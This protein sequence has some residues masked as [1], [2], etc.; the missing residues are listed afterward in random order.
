[1][2][3]LIGRKFTSVLYTCAHTQWSCEQRHTGG[4]CIVYT[5]LG[6]H[7]HSNGMECGVVHSEITMKLTND[8]D[9]LCQWIKNYMMVIQIIMCVRALERKRQHVLPKSDRFFWFIVYYSGIRLDCAVQCT[10]MWFHNTV[11]LIHSFC[12]TWYWFCLLS[13]NEVT[14]FNR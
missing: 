13:I 12:A 14:F 2:Y 4:T 3:N 6:I 10:K 1:M 5:T 8:K 11:S 9:K 7:S